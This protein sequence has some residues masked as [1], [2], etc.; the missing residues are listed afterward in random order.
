[1]TSQEMMHCLNCGYNLRGLPE[2]RCPECGQPFNPDDSETYRSRPRSGSV[3]LW[4]SLL[5]VA[6]FALP[7][8]AA[9][10][11]DAK[12]IRIPFFLSGLGS[13]MMVCGLVLALVTTSR[14][15]RVLRQP[16]GL[17]ARRRAAIAALLISL[18]VFCAFAAALIMPAFS[19]VRVSGS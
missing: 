14:S 7:L 18:V 10:L 16:R 15:V 19:R 8:A 3:L 2:N 11:A 1:M 5:S 12:V 6:L 4:L 17:L 13:A 9:G